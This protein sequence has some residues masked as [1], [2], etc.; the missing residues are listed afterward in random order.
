MFVGKF[1]NFDS[2]IGVEKTPKNDFF[3]VNLSF[4]G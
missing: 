3:P 4:Q 2:Y 1:E